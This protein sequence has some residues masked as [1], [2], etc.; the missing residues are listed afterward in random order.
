MTIRTFSGTHDFDPSVL[1]DTD[2]DERGNADE[3]LENVR[4]GRCPRC[5]GPLPAPPEYPAGSRVT[6]C[7]SIP[8]CGRCGHDE[9]LSGGLQSAGCWPLPTEE[10]EERAARFREHA[11]LAILTEGGHLIT[12]SG[13]TPVTNPRETGGWVQHGTDE[14]GP[15]GD[16]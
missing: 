6:A 10:I 1:V 5:E 7:R 8:I 4:D 11:R 13:S 9:A 16:D 2:A 12:E 15:D 14:A 3:I